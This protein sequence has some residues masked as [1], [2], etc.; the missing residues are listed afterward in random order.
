M[1]RGMMSAGGGVQVF[2]AKA[3][4]PRTVVNVERLVNLVEREGDDIVT[5]HQAATAIAAR[6]G[7]VRSTVEVATCPVGL[8]RGRLFIRRGV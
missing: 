3:A 1:E 4:A 7:D 5:V 2:R 6:A 8:R